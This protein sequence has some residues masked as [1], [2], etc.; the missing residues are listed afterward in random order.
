MIQRF[1]TQEIRELTISWVVLA[2]LFS[3]PW[4]IAGFPV[5]LFTLGLAFIGHELAHKFVAQNYGFLA[6]YRMDPQ[7]LVFAFFLA[8]ITMMG[9]FPIIFAAPGAVV[10]YPINRMGR[11]AT[12]G[13]AGRIAIAGVLINLTFA[14][15]FAL[16]S[17]IS[18][19]FMSQIASIG[20]WVNGFL[21]FFNLLPFGVLDGRK[22]LYWDKRI[23][24]VTLILALIT[25]SIAY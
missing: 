23:W 10:I 22:V 14:A 9:G 17:L 12:Q 5:I 7:N 4:G 19:G 11:P 21:A 1:T 16:L 3:I 2:V 8:I 13:Q 25:M 6:Q 15:F 24:L 20:L 18:G